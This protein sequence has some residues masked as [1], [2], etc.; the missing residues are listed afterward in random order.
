MLVIVDAYLL[1]KLYYYRKNDLET[2]CTSDN[3]LGSHK[4]PLV[5]CSSSSWKLHASSIEY[6]PGNSI[7]GVINIKLN[8]GEVSSFIPGYHN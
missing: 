1:G 5:M 6:S 7:M 8:I 4:Y 2:V 3:S